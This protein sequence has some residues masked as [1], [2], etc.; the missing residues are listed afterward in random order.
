MIGG[1]WVAYG[2]GNHVARHGEPRG[3]TE[4][5]VLAR[6]TFARD[7]GGW[8]VQRAEYVP[9]LVQL[10][11]PIRLLDLTA[12]PPSA[13]VVEAL[14]RTDDVVLSRGAGQA[15]LTRPQR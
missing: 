8:R 13:R 15:G 3:T 12:E 9:T 7:A 6:F 14:E 5:G 11:P 1:E 4:E 2:L 10:G